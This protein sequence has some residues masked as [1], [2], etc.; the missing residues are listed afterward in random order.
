VSAGC[1]YFA[2]STSERFEAAVLDALR[3]F[4]HYLVTVFSADFDSAEVLILASNFD[5]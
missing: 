4:S 2:G 5:L 3:E 1:I